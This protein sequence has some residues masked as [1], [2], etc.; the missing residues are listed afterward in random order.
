MLTIKMMSG[1]R[2][3]SRR[4]LIA[5]GGARRSGSSERGDQKPLSKLSPL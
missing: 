4:D 5:G 2:K 1:P 3:L